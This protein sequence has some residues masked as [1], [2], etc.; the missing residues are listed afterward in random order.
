[1]KKRTIKKNKQESKLKASFCIPTYNKVEYLADAV[2][3]FLEQKY[4][5]KELLI[6]DDASTDYTYQLAEFYASKYENIKYFKFETNIGVANMRNYLIEKAT[7]D[8]IFINDADDMR[9]HQFIR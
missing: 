9:L 5:N 6:G 7:G 1:M 2:E 3:S 8:I 4:E